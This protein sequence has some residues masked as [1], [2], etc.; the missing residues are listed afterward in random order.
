M[1]WNSYVI[2]MNGEVLDVTDVKAIL[3]NH[4]DDVA[5]DIDNVATPDF[6]ILDVLELKLK[7]YIILITISV[8]KNNKVKR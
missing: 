1:G 7:T 4:L 2:A 3:M 8:A 6:N 5:F